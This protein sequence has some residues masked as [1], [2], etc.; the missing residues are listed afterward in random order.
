MMHDAKSCM[1]TSCMSM[2]H[3]AA[4]PDV[5]HGSTQG[6]PPEPKATRPALNRNTQY[7]SWQHGRTPRGP[8]GHPK[9]G[10][11]GAVPSPHNNNAAEPG[12]LDMVVPHRSVRHRLSG[13]GGR[14][15]FVHVSVARTCQKRGM[16]P[17]VAVENAIKDPDW[18]IFK[19]PDR[20]E[21][22]RDVLAAPAVTMAAAC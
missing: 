9:T 21:R 4:C 22:E 3:D 16:F 10:P 20:P 15:V 19:P 8:T 11:L 14:E 5:L 7:D 17:R 18:R 1:A 12:M 13:R 2:L 6:P